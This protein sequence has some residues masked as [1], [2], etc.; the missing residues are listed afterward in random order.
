MASFL[1]LAGPAPGAASGFGDEA[2][3]PSL[4]AL[5]WQWLTEQIAPVEATTGQDQS[6]AGWI[7]DPDG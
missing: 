2:A 5:A 6:D 3:A 7:M 4:W 1:S